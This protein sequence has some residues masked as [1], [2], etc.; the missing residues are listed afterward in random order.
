[1]TFI[2][3]GFYL[4]LVLTV[5]MYYCL[6]M[7]VRWCLLMFASIGVYVYSCKYH[8]YQIAIFGFLVISSFF[9]A[10]IISKVSG[11]NRLRKWILGT[12]IAIDVFPLLFFK[13]GS[14]IATAIRHPIDISI[15]APLGISFYTLQII[16]YL[17]DVYRNKIVPQKNFGKYVL[18]VIFF[19]QIIQGP[20]PRYEQLST[21]L[22]EG[23]K[24][25]ER[26]FVKGFMLIVWG[27]FLKL[28]IAD[29][30]GI[31]VDQ[32]FSDQ[33]T[34]IG[35][36]VLVGGIL[37]SIQLYADFL[38]CV[39]IAR[40][41]AELFGIELV[42]NFNHPYFATSVK[43]FWRR[44]HI[45]LSMWLKDYIYIPLGGNRRGKVRKYLNIMVTFA[46]S[47]MWHGAGY[48]YVFWGMVH[49]VYQ[50]VGEVLQPL[51]K[52]TDKILNLREGSRA[53]TDIQ[54]VITF[55]LVMCDWIIFR[56]S[57]LKTGLI[58]IKSMLTKY[59]PWIFWDDSLLDL[60]LDW[61]ECFVLFVALL[62]LYRIGKLQEKMNIRDAVLRQPLFI[63]WGIYTVAITIIVLFGTW[64]M[65]Y[66]SK[67]F[68][69]G[70]F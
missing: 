13:E 42:N 36:Y 62:V 48:K 63:R 59:N 6:P 61:K 47:G 5:V 57:S 39:S 11:E 56:A 40:G 22:Y 69:Y 45:S 8:V 9:F 54:I 51:K 10:Q 1:M 58:M 34:Y 44:W 17:S 38:A 14:L 52:K 46:V 2:S 41:A 66:N 23:H 35:L 67:A 37:Y 25:D 64:G 27:F 29:K 7:K 16:A 65:G 43:D 20:I 32:I 33:Q 28:M 55:F 26:Q 60:G 68:I 50:I 53:K 24:F 70:G 12:F 21:Q 19:P 15:I 3:G 30:A 31:I 49:G 4:F 18:F